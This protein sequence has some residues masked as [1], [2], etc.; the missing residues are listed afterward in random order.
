MPAAGYDVSCVLGGCSGVPQT[1]SG[2]GPDQ[3]VGSYFDDE[4]GE[5]WRGRLRQPTFLPE[6]C[7]NFVRQAAQTVA[8]DIVDPCP[9]CQLPRLS[10]L[11]PLP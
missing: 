3:G 4:T 10:S 6:V 2:L 5:L 11:N 9:S 1:Y 8:L 7:R